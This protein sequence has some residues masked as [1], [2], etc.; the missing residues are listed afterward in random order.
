MVVFAPRSNERL[1]ACRPFVAEWVVTASAQCGCT[2]RSGNATGDNNHSTSTTPVPH[3]FHS[4]RFLQHYGI[5]AQRTHTYTML[6][7]SKDKHNAYSIYS[8]NTAPPFPYGVL[9]FALALLWT[10]KPRIPEASPRDS[11]PCGCAA[12]PNGSH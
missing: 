10:R 7:I 8:D 6:A 3:F 2:P 4:L 9:V 12:C 5:I 1:L 11:Q